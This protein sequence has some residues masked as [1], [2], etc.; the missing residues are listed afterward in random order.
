[1]YFNARSILPKVDELRALCV[2]HKPNIVCIVESWLDDTIANSELCIDN[3][4]CVRAD[5]SRHGGGVLIYVMDSL[6]FNVIFPGSSDLELIILSIS[7]TPPPSPKLCLGLFYRPPSSPCLTNTLYAFV[8]VSL[9]SNFV[10][11]GDFNV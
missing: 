10:L 3:Y 2:T 9:F 6:S 11:L 7:V 5:R 1:M 4:V 8:D